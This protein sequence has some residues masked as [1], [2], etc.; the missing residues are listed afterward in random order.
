MM[1]VAQPLQSI[2]GTAIIKYRMVFNSLASQ[3]FCSSFTDRPVTFKDQTSKIKTVM[4][5]STALDGSV[6]TEYFAQGQIPEFRLIF[7]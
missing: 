1:V 7:R 5:G 2:S 4:T 3:I 6:T